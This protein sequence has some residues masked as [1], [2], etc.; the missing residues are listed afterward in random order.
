MCVCV[1]IL[2]LSP[3]DKDTNGSRLLDVT[4]LYEQF[5]G[6]VKVD[7]LLHVTSIKLKRT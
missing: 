1:H 3:R 5:F 7:Q 6:T 4:S 2:L